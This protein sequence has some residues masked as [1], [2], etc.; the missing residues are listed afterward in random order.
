MEFEIWHLW[1][2]ATIVFV[3]LEIFV[4]S[5]VMMSI[6][7]GCFLAFLGA[8]FQAPT[9]FQ[10]FLFIVGTLAGFLA[11]KP[12]MIKYAYNRKSV[13]TNANGLIGRIGKVIE[14]ID[15]DKNT[16]CVAI[17]G[18]QWKAE[19]VGENI[20]PVNTKVKVTQVNSIVLT[21]EPVSQEN[22]VKEIVSPPVDNR[23]TIKVGNKTYFIG[24]DEILVLCSSNKITHIVSSSGKKY[25][26]DESLDRL[27]GILPIQKF[28]RVN[29]QFILNRDVISGIRSA[30][31]GKIEATL[32]PESGINKSIIISRL[33]AHAFRKWMDLA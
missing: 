27:S 14:E 17:D 13:E 32:H 9:A 7:T 22:H 24:F 16:G 19:P 2:L 26:H 4:P 29:R 15:P 5:F 21:V 18:D 6:A 30:A 23:L 33:K 10:L 12:L 25:I 28:F 20:I 31:N 11:V 8:L 1:I 3:V